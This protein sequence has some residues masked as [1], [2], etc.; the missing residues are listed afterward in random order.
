MWIINCMPSAKRLMTALLTLAFASLLQLERVEACFQAY[1]P[2]VQLRAQTIAGTVTLH[3]KPIDGAVLSLHKFLGAYSIE[4]SHADTNVLGRAITAKDG[5]F[6]FG[7][8]PNGKYVVFVRG[9]SINVEL[10]KSKSGE[11]DTV[12]I[13]NFADSCV[14]ATAISA[15]GRKLTH[16]LP[17][18]ILGMGGSTSMCW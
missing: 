7:E 17:S 9:A 6:K 8:V 14:S 15:D 11:S 3:G 18:A 5:H 13:E 1:F 2:S 10:V 4:L 16:G 12:A